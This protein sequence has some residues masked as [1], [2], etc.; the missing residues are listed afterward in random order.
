[1]GVWVFRS[2]G[3]VPFNPYTGGPST[4]VFGGGPTQRKSLEVV[5]A[6]DLAPDSAE[7]WLEV[8]KAAPK[9]GVCVSPEVGDLQTTGGAQG[10]RVVCLFLVGG[11][12]TR[13]HQGS[14]EQGVN[15]KKLPLFAWKSRAQDSFRPQM[16]SLSYSSTTVQSARGSGLPVLFTWG[17]QLPP[18]GVDQHSLRPPDR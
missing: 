17:N 14:P 8:Q 9:G 7:I 2:S 4:L 6:L 5:G 3:W 12:D 13:K 15:Q 10:P 16:G 18:S 1:M 11:S